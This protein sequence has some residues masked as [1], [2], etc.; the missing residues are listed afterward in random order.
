[1]STP[2]PRTSAAAEIT[3]RTRTVVAGVGIGDARSWIEQTLPETEFPEWVKQRPIGPAEPS[4]S[5][6]FS[7]VPRLRCPTWTSC[8]NTQ[9]SQVTSIC[10]GRN[11]SEMRE[12]STVPVITGVQEAVVPEVL[13]RVRWPDE[14]V[15]RCYS[16]STV[17]EDFFSAGESYSVGEFVALSRKALTAA[18][19]RVR[20]IY[21]FGCAQA[22]AQLADIERKA[23]GFTGQD[24]GV[25]VEGFER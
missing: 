14:S 19:E 10:S 2:H 16:P 5:V 7:T 1:V 22:A 20:Q 17:V 23:A 13:F 12:R 18:S 15:H 21:G 9:T 11:S 24:T 4:F 3:E 6:R 25:V 8:R